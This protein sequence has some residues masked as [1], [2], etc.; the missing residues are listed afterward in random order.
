V[1]VKLIIQGKKINT[2]KNTRFR[3]HKSFSIWVKVLE[4]FLRYLILVFWC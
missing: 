1:I 4:L 3:N 2:I